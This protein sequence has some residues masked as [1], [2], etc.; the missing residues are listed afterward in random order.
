MLV[1]NW[2]QFIEE[3]NENLMEAG[4]SSRS[5]LGNT[6]S[7]IQSSIKA[8]KNKINKAYTPGLVSVLKDGLNPL[9]DGINQYFQSRIDEL[10][11]KKHQILLYKQR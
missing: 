9:I 3:T 8:I 4:M 2:N 6:I 5:K 10:K 11:R 7:S 1:K